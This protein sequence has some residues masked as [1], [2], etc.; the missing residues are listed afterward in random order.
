MARTVLLHRPGKRRSRH[1]PASLWFG[2][3]GTGVGGGTVGCGCPATTSHA[4]TQARIGLLA[5]GANDTAAGFGCRGTGDDCPP[6]RAPGQLGARVVGADTL[7]FSER[8]QIVA[9]VFSERDQIVAAALT[10]SF[11]PERGAVLEFD[12]M[13]DLASGYARICSSP[14]VVE[15]QLRPDP[16][17]D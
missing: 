12:S 9:A 10:T 13:S 15:F 6:L 11:D 14:L 17:A 8:D 5:I 4:R 16:L 2:N 3:P 1:H 7:F